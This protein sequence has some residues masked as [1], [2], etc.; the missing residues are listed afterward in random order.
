MILKNM[1]Q[2]TE[3]THSQRTFL[4]AE[5]NYDLPADSIATAPCRPRDAAQLLCLKEGHLSHHR[6]RDLPN[7]LP[8]QAT[9][10]LN[11]SAVLPLRIRLKKDTG[12]NIEVLLLETT[13]QETH[14]SEVLSRPSPLRCRALL[15]PA[16]R[17]PIGAYIYGKSPK[18]KEIKI[19]RLSH[20]EVALHWQPQAT[21][22]K[23]ILIA[24][25]ETPL[26]PYMKRRAQ[27][28]D[29]YDY[30]CVYSKAAGSV[31][32]PTA[33]LHFTSK[34]LN[35]LQKAGFSLQYL[36]LHIGASTFLPLQSKDL[37]EHPM[38]VERM[39]ISYELL[40]ALIKSTYPVAVGTTSLR[41]LES[42]YWYGCLLAE[43]PSACLNIPRFIY[44]QVPA[45]SA[46]E[47]LTQ[48]AFRMEQ[49]QLSTLSGH[50]ALYIKPG[51]RLRMAKGLISNFHQPYST[52]LVL[53]AALIG[54]RWKALYQEALQK[55]YR[56][57]SYGDACIFLF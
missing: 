14:L 52:L 1:C 24:F 25:G 17:L 56:F 47:A 31:A 21:L 2:N 44:K 53:V 22:F 54:P 12:A 11:Q 28:R 34:L 16:A 30:Q 9:L 46:A 6:F 50:T 32:A 20:D 5:Y 35:T 27:P 45:L 10:F 48:V 55:K 49:A 19:Q 38:H 42:L 36:N 37:R 40:Q 13:A 33:G 57:L 18:D 26:P 4:S 23:D 3:K 8:T 39:S 7:L 15:R 41:T 51:Y 29:L 43:Q